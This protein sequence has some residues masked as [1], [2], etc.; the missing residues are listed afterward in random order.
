MEKTIQVRALDTRPIGKGKVHSRAI[1]AFLSYAVAIL[2]GIV[3]ETWAADPLVVRLWPGQPPGETRELPPEAD[4]TKP[5]DKLIGGRRII[6]LGNVSTPQIAVY[7]PPA[8][9][10][11][12][13]AVVICPGG[14]H[15][16]LAYD[17]EGTEVAEWLNSIGVTGVVLKYR[18]PYRDP[19]KRWL[20]AV[21]DA[22]RAMSLVRSKA[23]DWRLDSKRIGMCGFSAGGQTAA[24]TALFGRRQYAPQ[25]DADQLPYRPDFAILVYPGG[26]AER[27]Q[28]KLCDYV[29]VTKDAPPMFFVHAFDDRVSVDNSLLLASQLKQAGGSAELHVYATG[30]HGY[31]LRPTKE[32]VTHWPQRAGQWMRE[33]GYLDTG[34]RQ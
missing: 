14:G 7:H 28:S 18:V 31:G 8:E 32:A 17:L 12:G 22:Q 29:T 19:E 34:E 30:G 27:D 16:I 6:K 1:G 20:A 24:L 26:L 23:A 15:H 13:A 33:Q 21:Q 3:G 25:D 4:Q 9:K 10:A 5:T 2:A 11:T